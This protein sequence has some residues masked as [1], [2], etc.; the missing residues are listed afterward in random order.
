MKFF[1]SGFGDLFREKNNSKQLF[2]YAFFFELKADF[3]ER[4]MK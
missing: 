2:M 4:S 3:F 1:L